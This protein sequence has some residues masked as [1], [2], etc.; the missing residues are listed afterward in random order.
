MPFEEARASL[1]KAKFKVKRGDDVFSSEIDE[2]NVVSTEPGIGAEAP[3]QSEVLVRVSKGP[4]LVTVPNLANLRSEEASEALEERGLEMDV[5][6]SFKRNDRITGQDP[7]PGARVERGSSVTVTFDKQDCI[8]F[9][10]FD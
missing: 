9:I 8:L 7:A 1:T 10:C 4:D 3:F 6:G 5:D 2:G